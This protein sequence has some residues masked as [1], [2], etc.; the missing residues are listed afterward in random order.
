M[1]KFLGVDLFCFDCMTKLSLNR[2]SLNW[3]EY[4]INFKDNKSKK[5]HIRKSKL[6]FIHIIPQKIVRSSYLTDKDRLAMFL[7]NTNLLLCCVVMETYVNC[8]MTVWFCRKPLSF[9]LRRYF[10]ICEKRNLR[11]TISRNLMGTQIYNLRK[12]YY[13]K[14][15]SSKKELKKIKYQ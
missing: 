6:K 13:K 9:I 2:T 5:V 4:S 15:P 1:S 10:I 12:F 3:V 11:S 8:G 7:G 14:C